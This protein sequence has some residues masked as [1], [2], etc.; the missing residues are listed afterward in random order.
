L[1]K[2]YVV[3]I[4]K[5]ILANVKRSCVADN[6]AQLELVGTCLVPIKSEY[7]SAKRIL[8]FL[9]VRRVNVLAMTKTYVT[10]LILNYM[11]KKLKQPRRRQLIIQGR[12]YQRWPVSAMIKIYFMKKKIEVSF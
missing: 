12:E 11:E 9:T 10:M 1:V 4:T 3:F 5:L 2:H 7:F 6:Q 8:N